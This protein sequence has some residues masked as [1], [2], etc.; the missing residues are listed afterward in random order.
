MER[1]ACVADARLWLGGPHAVLAGVAARGPGLGCGECLP[2][3]VGRTVSRARGGGR[4]R[5]ARLA[6]RWSGG[7]GW[8]GV[9]S[10]WVGVCEV[11]M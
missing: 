6:M 4:P 2:C 1:L 5:H 11:Y 7:A 3:A 8:C 9:V 10:W